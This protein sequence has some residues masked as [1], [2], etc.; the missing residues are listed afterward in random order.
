MD[1]NKGFLPVLTLK[2][3][4]LDKFGP[5][6]WT[7]KAK[8]VTLEFLSEPKKVLN[9]HLTRQSRKCE[10]I[11]FVLLRIYWPHECGALVFGGW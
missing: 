10:T 9:I 2:F 8:I 4:A 6:G 11:S 7:D 5:N 3:L 1:K